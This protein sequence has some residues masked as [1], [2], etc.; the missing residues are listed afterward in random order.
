MI[1][2][3]NMNKYIKDK[4]IYTSIDI[5]K[6]STSNQSQTPIY[7]KIRRAQYTG[8]VADVIFAGRDFLL[9]KYR[10]ISQSTKLSP[11]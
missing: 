6:I 4:Y 9:S 8:K 2:I 5:F 1:I 7:T 11:L 10:V 3:V